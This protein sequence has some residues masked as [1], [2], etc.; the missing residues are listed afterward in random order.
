MVT[1]KLMAMHMEFR[2]K[3]RSQKFDRINRFVLPSISFMNFA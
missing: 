2:E 3:G 1:V